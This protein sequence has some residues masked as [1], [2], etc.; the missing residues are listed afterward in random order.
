[1]LLGAANH[2]NEIGFE[3]P[4]LGIGNWTAEAVKIWAGSQG[5][6]LAF[7]HAGGDVVQLIPYDLHGVKRLGIP[8]IAHQEYT[9]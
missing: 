2:F 4:T 3:H 8:G 5:Q 7:H 1:M 9:R 6:S